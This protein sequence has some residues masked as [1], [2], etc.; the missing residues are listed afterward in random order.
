MSA[1]EISCN[2]FKI[3]TYVENQAKCGHYL[4]HASGD[5]APTF[6][7]YDKDTN[8][9]GDYNHNNKALGRQPQIS[10]RSKK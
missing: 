2:I 6:A 5:S 4:E 1:S 8:I 10:N 9:F 3:T 7:D